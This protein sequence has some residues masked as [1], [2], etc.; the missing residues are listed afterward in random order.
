MNSSLENSASES[1]SDSEDASESEATTDSSEAEGS[2]NADDD[3]DASA[4]SGTE[5]INAGC[6]HDVRKGKSKK[7]KGKCARAPHN[8][9]ARKQVKFTQ[10]QAYPRQWRSILEDAKKL[11][12]CTVAIKSGFPERRAG[13]KQAE[14]CLAEAMAAHEAGDGTVEEG[15]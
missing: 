6:R 8:S 13:L 9:K 3:S 12:R 11:N 2:S 5:D 14:D 1:G 10:L 15:M 4:G 7:G